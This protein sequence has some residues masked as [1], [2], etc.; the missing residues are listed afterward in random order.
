MK[1]VLKLNLRFIKKKFFSM[2]FYII[3]MEKFYFTLGCLG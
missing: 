3:S 1:S 2:D